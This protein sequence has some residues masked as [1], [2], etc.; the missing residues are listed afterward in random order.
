MTLSIKL[1]LICLF[2][3]YNKVR[4]KKFDLGDFAMYFSPFSGSGYPDPTVP[5]PVGGGGTDLYIPLYLL[6][7]PLIEG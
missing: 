3:A 6:Y 7:A 4:L 2:N 1:R 5:L